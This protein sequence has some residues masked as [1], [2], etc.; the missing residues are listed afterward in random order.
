MKLFVKTSPI[1]LLEKEK[2]IF[3]LA[4][5]ILCLF[6]SNAAVHGTM[7]NNGSFNSN[8][9]E[10]PRTVTGVITDAK[11]GE[12]LIGVNIVVQG[13]NTGVIT[14]F[15]GKYSITVPNS[16]AI[17][18]FSYIGYNTETR[19]V[20]DATNL[21][22]GLT[23][24][25]ESLDEVVVIGYGTQRKISVTGAI[26]TVK[27]EEILKSPVS[28]INNALAGRAAG[29]ITVQSTSEPGKD[30]AEIFIRGRATTGNSSPLILVDG[31]E[32]DMTTLDPN[33][34]ESINILKDASATAVYGVR[35]ANGVIIVTTKVGRAST[36]P[37]V[38]FNYNYSLQEYT[39]VPRLLPAAEWMKMY[40]QKSY[41]DA[42]NKATWI[43]PF[44]GE[45]IEKWRSGADPIF[46]P[47]VNWWDVMLTQWVPS[48][49]EN[50]NVSGGT[51]KAR[52]FVSLG[53]YFADGF[54]T[55]ANLLPGWNLN[56]TSNTYNIRANTDFDWTDRFSTSIKFGTQM[57]YYEGTGQTNLNAHLNNG[58]ISSP[59]GNT[60]IVDGKLIQRTDEL[61][62]YASGFSPWV[63]LYNGGML[64][65]FT[66]RTN[67][68][69]TSRYELDFITE[70]LSIRGKFAYD[71]Y[72]RQ[73]VNSTQSYDQYRI[74]R[75]GPY[76]TPNNYALVQATYWGPWSSTE[77]FDQ[78]ARLYGEGALEYN[79]TLTGGHT[80]GGLFLGT[81]E[82][83]YDGGTPALPFNYMGLV[84]RVTYNYRQKYMTDINMGYNGSENFAPGNQFGFFPSFALGYVVSE[85]SFFPKNDVFT[86]LKIRG[87]YGKVGND[88]I[89][90]R[91]A[92]T[93][94]AFALA[95]NQYWFGRDT[96]TGYAGYGESTIGNPLISWEVSTK[97]NIAAELKFFKNQLSLSA[98]LFKENREGIYGKYNNVSYI[99]GDVSKL[100]SFNLGQVEN[101][102]YEINFDFRPSNNSP[103]QYYFEGNYSFSKNK[104][105]YFDEVPP[106]YPNLAQTG[107]PIGQRF[108]LIVE[109][110]YTTWDEINDPARIKS[111]W[112]PTYPIQPGDLKY[113]DVNEDGIIDTNDR[114]P[115]GYTNVPE[116]FFGLS[117][118]FSYN[119]WDV[120]VL[121]Q[122]ATH[123]MDE[124]TGEFV[125]MK[126][127]NRSINDQIY[128]QWT[129]EKYLSGDNINFPRHTLEAGGSHNHQGNTYFLEDASY[130]RLKN[131]EVGYTL[132]RSFSQKLRMQ[133]FRINLSG[134]NLLTACRQYAWDPEV[135]RA[136]GSNARGKYPVSR[137]YNIGVRVNF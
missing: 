54:Y 108:G 16:N 81:M 133:N 13:T 135:S 111:I 72:Y 37:Q 29:V 87:S 74:V 5:S 19:A 21:T 22:L 115:M 126:G 83:E 70:G 93:P 79:R 125:G 94:D 60:P 30:V 28:S 89:G 116:I 102:G 24:E 84:A 121:I 11:T 86:F 47:D 10:Q 104:R 130:L 35:G 105:V 132:P 107:L 18:I 73:R 4:V 101:K 52:Y 122:G 43:A 58:M 59:I 82:R 99:F 128:D 34:V 91:F 26:S 96:Y 49:R 129:M 95:N 62:P 33:E 109:G 14:D 1:S 88:N 9:D 66:S 106:L 46:N 112:E 17:L 85:E 113:K 69:L 76:G 51:K 39:R 65:T 137:I 92:F 67:I 41:T 3:I 123:V 55:K 134:Q 7:A 110:F 31:V 61:L 114:A 48:G 15:T 53:H 20:G 68:D 63:Q 78:T 136:N 118:G 97:S 25:A 23:A 36:K 38:S 57:F 32:R 117:T 27:S 8:P 100:P 12:P 42:S 6:L 40:N 50:L 64:N 119:N 71:N 124:L 80:L 103:F 127:I 90:A 131:L 45:Q 44:T 56:S 120:S 2:R 77:N 75:T 98:E